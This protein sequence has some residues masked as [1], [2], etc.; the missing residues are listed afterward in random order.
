MY[1]K[2]YDQTSGHKS[3]GVVRREISHYDPSLRVSVGVSA[4]EL[5]DRITILQIKARRLPRERRT[6]VRRELA[7]ARSTRDRFIVSSTKL[8]SLTRALRTVNRR[9]W[10]VEEAL[11][12][13]E[14]TG[15]FGPRFVALARSVYKTNDR[16]AALKR[17]L[18]RLL[19][20]EIREHKSY[21]LPSLRG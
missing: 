12:T 16:R 3:I 8:A 4:G 1:P 7:A 2:G 6:G 20:S 13:C 19:G 17:Q 21:R 9:L 11:R 10:D 18:D 5:I 15:Q 14:R